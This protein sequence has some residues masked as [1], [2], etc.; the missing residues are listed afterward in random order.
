MIEAIIHAK[1]KKGP[2]CVKV[3]SGDYELFDQRTGRCI[4]ELN[5]LGLIPGSYITMTIVVGRY[6]GRLVREVCARYGCGV[7]RLKRINLELNIW[8][9]L[10]R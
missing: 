10:S 9:V 8:Y 2:G 6:R 4:S 7:S 5:F 3:R 1:F